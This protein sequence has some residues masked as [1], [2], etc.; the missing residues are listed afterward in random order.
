ASTA[1]DSGIGADANCDSRKSLAVLAEFEY[2]AG[3][4]N[5]SNHYLQKAIELDP[6]FALARHSYG[7]A[8]VRAQDYEGAQNQL[9][10]AF[11]LQPDNARFAYVYAVS[12]NSAGYREEAEEVLRAGLGYNP[13]DPDLQSF[14]A[15]LTQ[16]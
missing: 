5:L 7:L 1:R 10:I 2:R 4:A 9:R 12:L 14:L 3:N 6:R 11:N 8:L 15:I 13:D 16:N